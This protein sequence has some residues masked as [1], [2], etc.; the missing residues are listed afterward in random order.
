MSISAKHSTPGLN[1][2]LLA[3]P[4]VFDKVLD[5]R[6]NSP[7]HRKR[8]HRANAIA[9]GAH[10]QRQFTIELRIDYADND[11]NEVMTKALKQAGRHILT[12]ALLLRDEG[13][14]PQ[15]VVYSDDFFAGH[16]ELKILDDII[17]EGIEATGG[18]EP[19]GV[20]EDLMRAMTT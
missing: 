3:N 20:S 14:E 4:D 9:E 12:T 16:S 17:A 5:W 18:E 8:K 15:I 19:T 11:K 6:L 2:D 1:I 10:M 13:M 7:S